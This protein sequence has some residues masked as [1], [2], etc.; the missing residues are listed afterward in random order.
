MNQQ[1]STTSNTP[2]E[3]LLCKMG[4]GFFGS[5]ATGDCCSKCWRELQKKKDMDGSSSTST[6]S[7]DAVDQPTPMEVDTPTIQPTHAD[8]AATPVTAAPVASESTAEKVEAPSQPKVVKKKKKKTSYK[9]MMA[10]MTKR[11]K[12]ETDIEKEKEGLRKVTG[13]GAFSKIDKI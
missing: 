9:S 1:S 7:T 6:A 10:N 5:N 12:D 4:C 2:A 3:P 13:G 8:E 11:T